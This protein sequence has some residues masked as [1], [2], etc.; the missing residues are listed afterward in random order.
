M[1]AL[2]PRAALHM[3]LCISASGRELV[4]MPCNT[5]GHPTQRCTYFGRRDAGKNTYHNPSSC[6]YLH[7]SSAVH[8]HVLLVAHPDVTPLR[9]W[10]QKCALGC[11]TAC[12][13]A[14]LAHGQL[15]LHITAA[16]NHKISC[17]QSLQHV[18]R[19]QQPNPAAREQ[20]C[21]KPCNNSTKRTVVGQHR[22]HCWQLPQPDYQCSTIMLS[23]H[24]TGDN[25]WL[26]HSQLA[27]GTQCCYSIW[28]W[29][30]KGR[31]GYRTI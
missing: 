30:A 16:F 31:V 5:H 10:L 12:C 14:V 22:C 23:K 21:A 27:A 9:V 6:S 11:T 7:T 2:F 26:W 17:M 3:L 29:C 20:P 19:P 15:C 25:I 18:T 8:M 13:C 28:C 1:L 4:D 24:F